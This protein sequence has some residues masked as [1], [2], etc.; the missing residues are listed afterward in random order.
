[1]FARTF[2][3]SG[4]NSIVILD[5][6]KTQ[7]E[8]AA[9]DLVSWFEEHGGAK[10][11]EV[12]ALGLGCDVA[13]EDDVKKCFAQVVKKYGRVDVLVTAAGIVGEYPTSILLNRVLTTCICRELP[14]DRLPRREVQEA[15]GRQW[16]V[17]TSP[18]HA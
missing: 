7:A 6:D 1:M 13:N 15:H 11:G 14:C 16:S 4:S 5:L 17:P 12:R 8:V 2:V 18:L 9:K 10:K 3:E